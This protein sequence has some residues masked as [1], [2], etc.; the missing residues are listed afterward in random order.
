MSSNRR[1]CRRV[2]VSRQACTIASGSQPRRLNHAQTGR[3]GTAAMDHEITGASKARRHATRHAP[4]LAV[5]GAVALAIA[6]G[7]GL[8]LL[9]RGGGE[10]SLRRQAPA[11][12]A[13]PQ[14]LVAF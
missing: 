4:V 6:V 8:W 1:T 9:L 11:A 12:A 10:K 14:R 5:A 13:S 2:T 7:L 3:T